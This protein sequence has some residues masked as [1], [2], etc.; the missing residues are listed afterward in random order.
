MSKRV[1]VSVVV[2]AGLAALGCG[3][4]E[5][6]AFDGYTLIAPYLSTSTY[7]IDMAGQIVHRWE[8]DE[9]PAGGAYLLDDGRLLRCADTENARFRSNGTGGRIRLLDWDGNLVW[10]YLVSDDQRMQNHDFE[11]LPNGNVLV[12]AWD[13]RSRDEAIAAGYDPE[14]ASDKGLW[15]CVLIEIEPVLPDGGNV[16]WEWNAWDHLV[17]D[18]DP[19]KANYGEVAAHAE[20]LDVNCRPLRR[21]LDEALDPERQAEVQEEMRELE[22]QMRSLGY[23]GDEDEEEEGEDGSFDGGIG[24]DFMHVNGV[25]FDPGLDLIVLSCWELSEI[26]VVDHSTTTEEAAGHTGGRPVSQ[27]I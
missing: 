24:T 15:P 2:V 7:L 21:R 20:L 5:E 27:S 16:V 23:L 22:E 26:L 19:T 4:S 25:S 1:D 12:A 8:D 6:G 11:P 18:F 9:T 17:Q 3:R 13:Y 10:D 14:Q